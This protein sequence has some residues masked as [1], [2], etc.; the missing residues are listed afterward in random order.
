MRFGLTAVRSRLR[1]RRAG[2][3]ATLIVVPAVVIAASAAVALAATDVLGARGT[4][5]A[6]QVIVSPDGHYE[7]A[8]QSDGNLVEY[9]VGGHALWATGTHGDDGAHALMQTNGNLALYGASG[10]VVW[11]SNSHTTGCPQLVIQNDGNV[12]IYAPKPI[13]ATDAV[14]STLKPGDLLRPGWAIYSPPPEDF[15]LIM[16]GDG[17]L[18]LYDGAGKATWA[19]GTDHDPGAHAV[20]QTDGNLVVY[21]T[22]GKAVWASATSR[23]PGAYVAL[24]TDG[25]L[26]IY[27]GSTPLWASKTNGVGGGP[28]QAPAAPAPISC[29]LPSPPPVVTTPPPPVTTVPVTTPI[30]TPKPAPHRL[31]IKLAISWTWDR[32]ITW[33]QKVKIGT[34]PGRTQIA[35]ECK[36]HGCPRHRKAT[37]TGIRHLRHLL[38]RLRGHR[39]RSGDRLLITLEAPGY[40]PERAEVTFRYGRLP[41][42]RLLR[43]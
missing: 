29:A 16:Q 15:R 19:S 20:M 43:S 42:V 40:L 4:L 35:L 21:A 23:H 32:A 9:V 36:G 30:P 24:Q 5:S 33:L 41:E 26:V 2:G 8:M 39:Y 31:R 22:D 38:R 10:D 27:L 37:A 25:N 3:I 11:S 17:N 6:G 13:W 1:A 28:S 14:Q 12:V 7:L 34:F 18:V